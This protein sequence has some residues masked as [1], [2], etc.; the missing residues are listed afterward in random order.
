MIWDFIKQLHAGLRAP[1]NSL[2][3][4]ASKRLGSLAS[5][6]H[7]FDGSRVLLHFL[8]TSISI[9]LTEV[10]T[11]R[12]YIAIASGSP[13]CMR[14]A[15]SAS[16]R[17]EITPRTSS[18]SYLL[19]SV[20]CPIW[21]IPRLPGSRAYKDIPRDAWNCSCHGSG[22]TCRAG[23]L[24]RT[25]TMRPHVRRRSNAP[26][27]AKKLKDIKSCG[28]VDDPGVE[29]VT[30]QPEGSGRMKPIEV[31]ALLCL[32]SLPM[33]AQSSGSTDYPAWCREQLL[34]TPEIRAM[35]NYLSFLGVKPGE[36]PSRRKQFLM[37]LSEG[38]TGFG[39]QPTPSQQA[40]ARA[41]EEY[42]AITAAC[43]GTI[44]QDIQSP[45]GK[46]GQ[47]Q[48]APEVSSF[49]HV[50]GVPPVSPGAQQ[51]SPSSPSS[52]S[53]PELGANSQQKKSNPLDGAIVTSNRVTINND[54]YTMRPV[55][56]GRYRIDNDGADA[57]STDGPDS[58][59]VRP[60]GDGTYRVDSDRH[61]N[62]SYT[63]RP[64]GHGRYRIDK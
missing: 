6:F 41:Q 54:S 62:E 2:F 13:C 46:G 28:R 26:I 49:P 48:Q 59:T 56:A 30:T 38:L 21:P 1:V 47:P 60:R 19:S 20:P 9:V 24:R 52:L 12:K 22:R 63:M 18:F 7:E 40:L 10:S 57:G 37:Y 16:G 43:G 58:Y 25:T 11:F 29:S 53:F 14:F 39:H 34:R 35:E 4:A 5:C 27:S 55:G 3:R 15:C 36:T 23:P 50:P 31:V 51:S 17:T 61:P 64:R 42:R 32:A 8:S 45:S 33:L 44:P